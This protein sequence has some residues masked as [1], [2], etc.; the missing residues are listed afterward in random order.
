MSRIPR[1][2][3]FIDR[4]GTLI[5]EVN[6]LSKPEDLRIFPFTAEA[7]RRLKENGYLV[8][9]ITNQSGIGR[10]L[11]DEASMHAI[12]DIIQDDLGGLIDGV[13]FC[14][15]LPDE[16]CACRK[17]GTG[18]IEQADQD[19]GIDM[20]ASW[21]VGDKELDIQ[22]GVKAGTRTALVLTGYGC[23]H[24]EQLTRQPDIVAEDLL[25]AVE[26]IIKN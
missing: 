4:D 26:M 7:V 23:G 3:V 6:F 11:F 22:T 18:M 20:D 5:E 13:Y 21:M 17:P 2:A 9:V 8:I 25:A 10:N 19:L 24:L 15:H 16:G 1:K 12:H 14:P